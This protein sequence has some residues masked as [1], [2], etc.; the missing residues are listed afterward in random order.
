[1]CRDGLRNE[2]DDRQTRV[3]Q[4]SFQTEENQ[5]TYPFD[6][7]SLLW[8]VLVGMDGEGPH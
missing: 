2:H 1:M 4:G 5:R 7:L 6:N 8:R 3:I